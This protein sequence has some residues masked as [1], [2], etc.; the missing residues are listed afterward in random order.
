MIK[1]TLSV[2][3]ALSLGVLVCIPVSLVEKGANNT[4]IMGSQEHTN[5]WMC[6]DPLYCL[7]AKWINQFIEE[8]S[9]LLLQS[10]YTYNVYYDQCVFIMNQQYGLSPGL[11]SLT[12]PHCVLL[13]G[14]TQPS[15]PKSSWCLHQTSE[16][17]DSLLLDSKIIA[18]VFKW[19]KLKLRIGLVI[20]DLA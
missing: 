10:R 6:K 20:S 4:K 13:P 18:V 12:T 15:L 14:Q 7:L 9:S 3:S 8:L 19:R 17:W 16:H 5:L 11:Y 1:T 2:H